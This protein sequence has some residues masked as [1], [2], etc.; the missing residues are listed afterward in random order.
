MQDE[1]TGSH[2]TEVINKKQQLRFKKKI[3]S[4]DGLSSRMKTKKG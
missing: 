1:G 3:P 4:T 2:K